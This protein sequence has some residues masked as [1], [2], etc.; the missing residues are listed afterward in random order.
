MSGGDL[1]VAQAHAGVEHGRHERV[2]EHVR[3]HPRHPHPGGGGQVF[4]PAGGGV[5]VHPGSAGVA[6]DRPVGA[7]VDRG[8]DPPGDRGWERDEDDLAA[9]AVDLEDVVAVCSS[10]RSL[11]LAPQAS[12]IRSPSRPSMATRA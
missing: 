11:M 3:V 1:Y 6:Q 12:K 2:P 5:A 10:P 9:L 8:V 7:A 4:E